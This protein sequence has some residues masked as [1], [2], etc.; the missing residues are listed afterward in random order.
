VRAAQHAQAIALG[1]Q[2]AAL[3]AADLA[4]VILAAQARGQH[5]LH[6]LVAQGGAVPHWLAQP[7]GQLLP[8]GLTDLQH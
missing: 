3:D 1:E 6:E 5:L 4:D 2:E 7:P 8:A